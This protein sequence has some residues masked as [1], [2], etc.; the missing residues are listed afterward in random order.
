MF[1]RVCM[2]VARRM[3]WKMRN[4][5]RLCLD[6]LLYSLKEYLIDKKLGIETDCDNFPIKQG[7]NKDGYEYEPTRFSTIQFL[8]DYLQPGRDDVLVEYG[9][10]KGRIVCMFAR[11]RLANSIGIELDERLAK[12][13][14]SN[15]SQLKG[16]VS[17]ARVL[18]M[19]AME[20]QP[21]SGTIFFIFNSFG[22][23]T[24]CGVLD[25]IQKS[26]ADQPRCIRIVYL[27][28]CHEWVLEKHGWLERETIFGDLWPIVSIWRSSPEF[29]QNPRPI[30][31]K[32]KPAQLPTTDEE[33][34]SDERRGARAP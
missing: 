29:R 4:A 10:G 12:I 21:T 14:E 8:I 27:K 18:I 30:L 7:T 22:P 9:C 24:L 1:V 31:S 26:I 33:L 15:L 25:Q 19:D 28:P 32:N 3:F 5:V 23:K 17:N 2:N 16:K 20:F 11:I 6:D 13:A 34:P